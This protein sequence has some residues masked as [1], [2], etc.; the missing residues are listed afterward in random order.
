[1]RGHGQTEK[2]YPDA[3]YTFGVLETQDVLHVSRWLQ[4]SFPHVRRTG[5]A[6]FCWGANLG[7]LAG[8]YDG[9]G[10]DHPSVQPALRPYLDPPTGRKH[11]EAGILAIGPVVDWENLVERTDVQHFLVH[12][13]STFFFQHTIQQRMARKRF[14]DPRGSLRYLI[15][16]EFQHSAFGPSLPIME[17][18]RFLRFLPHKG[19]PAD[20]KLECV[21]V[22]MVIVS[23][24]N[25]PFLDAQA[26]AELM[27]KTGNPTVAALMLR[28]G[29]HIGFA[30]YNQSYYYSVILNF[31][32]PQSG[33]AALG[34][35][36]EAELSAG[37]SRR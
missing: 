27:T 34:S 21:R 9:C 15:N 25:D 3:Y 28:G 23:S 4:D 2:Y 17:A 1:M 8:W 13:P 5:L 37:R 24:V 19:L 12:D 7:M 29:G 22:P 32:D 30:A 33:A 6:G 36:Q 10:K 11:Y 35:R 16:Y 26:M 14:R 20:D 18:Y 31:F